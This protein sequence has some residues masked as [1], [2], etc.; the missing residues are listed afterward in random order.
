MPA[1]NADQLVPFQRAML[2]ACRPPAVWNAPPTTRSPFAAVVI[3]DTP[4]KSPGPDGPPT[5]EPSADQVPVTRSTTATPFAANG[6]ALWKPPPT[7]STGGSGPV[8]SRSHHV[9][10]RTG[11]SVP[12]RVGPGNH[13]VWHCAVARGI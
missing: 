1:P 7:T 5:P 6:P 4:A 13:C 11:E 12:A 2:P 9:V 3:A 10:A 8:P